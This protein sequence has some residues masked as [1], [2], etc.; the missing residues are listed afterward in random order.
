MEVQKV[1]KANATNVS[2]KEEKPTESVSFTEVMAKKRNDIV[3][4]RIQ[5]QVQEIE[6]QGKKLAESQTIEDLKKI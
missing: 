5:Q 1:T 6:A 2:R 4:E 3:F